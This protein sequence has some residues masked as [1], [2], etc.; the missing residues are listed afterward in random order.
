MPQERGKTN[1]VSIEIDVRTAFFGVQSTSMLTLTSQ[2]R[3]FCRT[4]CRLGGNSN[5]HNRSD[6]LTTESVVKD[7]CM[8]EGYQKIP[9][10][11]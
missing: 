10:S 2:G 1:E 6:H 11:K 4:A 9:F 8:S 7:K 3:F 5:V